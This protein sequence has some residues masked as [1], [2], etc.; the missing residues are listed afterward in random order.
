MSTESAMTF[1][2]QWS[3]RMTKAK[4]SAPEV[5]DGF[6]ALHASAMRE[7]T[8][9]VREKE[10]IATGI[11]MAL[12]CDA[13]VLSHVQKALQVGATRAQVL[14]AAG[15]VVMMQGGPGYTYL[16]KLTEALDALEAREEAREVRA[17]GSK[18]RAQEVT[19]NNGIK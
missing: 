18:L 17:S 2:D 4:A 3:S 12:R 11:A 14:E 10:L 19:L 8:L 15:V 9:S 6:K 13:C 16:P 5:A 1:Y 7:G